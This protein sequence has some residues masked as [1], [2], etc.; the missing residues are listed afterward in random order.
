MPGSGRGQIRLDVCP[1]YIGRSRCEIWFFDIGVRGQV[2][3][4]LA[5]EGTLMTNPKGQYIR[6]T[7]KHGQHRARKAL[8]CARTIPIRKSRIFFVRRALRLAPYLGLH[9]GAD[10]SGPYNRGWAEE[11][12]D[13]SV[14]LQGRRSALLIPRYRSP[15]ITDGNSLSRP[16]GCRVAR[17]KKFLKLISCP[18]RA[19]AK[20]VMVG[21]EKDLG[22]T[23]GQ[24]NRDRRSDPNDRSVEE[25]LLQVSDR[26]VCDRTR[27][28]RALSKP[29]QSRCQ[30]PEHGTAGRRRL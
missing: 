8:R 4:N 22:V 14:R 1:Y 3:P 12:D 10:D 30:C 9:E 17:E 19:A 23:P 29:V 2:V 13:R 20:P 27:N 5:Q 18:G 16:H 6:S 26:Q 24:R 25:T 28:G 21:D 15:A 7:T 11:G